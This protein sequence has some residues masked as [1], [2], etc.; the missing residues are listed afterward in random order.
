MQRKKLWK[1][2]GWQLGVPSKH[3]RSIDGET[4]RVT[5]TSSGWIRYEAPHCVTLPPSGR[6]MLL[7]H[8]V[9]GTP[10]GNHVVYG[11]Y[12]PPPPNSSQPDHFAPN[13][14]EAPN[15]V[16]SEAGKA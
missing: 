4:G 13:S 9:C 14:T 12:P 5:G 10:S 8:R 15:A 11:L 6:W 7:P 1:G 2:E 16:F 3:H